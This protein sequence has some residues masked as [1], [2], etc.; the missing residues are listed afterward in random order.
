MNIGGIF[1]KLGIIE[2][3]KGKGKT[4]RDLDNGQ[5]DS[6]TAARIQHNKCACREYQITSGIL[7]K[8]GRKSR[9]YRSTIMGH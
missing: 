3:R 6:A 7:V 5:K 8:D 2:G 9:E 4:H 1:K